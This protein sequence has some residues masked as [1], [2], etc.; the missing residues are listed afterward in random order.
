MDPRTLARIDSSGYISA[1]PPPETSSIILLTSTSMPGKNICR[2]LLNPFN[3]LSGVRA[4]ASGLSILIATALIA[5]LGQCRFDG[6]LGFHLGSTDHVGFGINLIE[7][8]V[9]WLLMSSLLF[10][11]GRLITGSRVRPFELFATQALARGPLLFTALAG[12]FPGSHRYALKV[13]P[14]GE[15]IAVLPADAVF[16]C[17]TLAVVI[18][19]LIWMVAL[20]YRSFKFS[21]EV[22]GPKALGMFAIALVTGEAISLLLL[23]ALV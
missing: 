21:C 14:G 8:L 17:L 11:G 4:L 10:A 20:Q 6:V 13:L 3:Y 2:L 1:A 9:A 5:A 19:M 18:L 7:V 22:S 12:M 16:Y 15:E 23:I